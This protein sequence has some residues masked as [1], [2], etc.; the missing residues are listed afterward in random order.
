M[1]RTWEQ[2]S[3]SVGWGLGATNLPSETTPPYKYTLKQ[4]EPKNLN[5]NK[6]RKADTK[7]GMEK[8]EG[9][10]CHKQRRKQAV[11]NFVQTS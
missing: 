1:C 7:E 2:L 10:L 3:W 8:K 11:L 4:Q 9:E 6:G 5:I